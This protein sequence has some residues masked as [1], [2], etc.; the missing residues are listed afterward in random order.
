M[1]EHWYDSLVRHLSRTLKKIQGALLLKVIY[2][3]QSGQIHPMIEKCLASASKAAV[4][5]ILATCEKD[6]ES[7]SKHLFP[8]KKETAT[9]S[10][11]QQLKVLLSNASEGLT[12]QAKKIKDLE[13]ILA[14]QVIEKRRQHESLSEREKEVA[15]LASCLAVKEDRARRLEEVLASRKNENETLVQSVSDK[16]KQLA[17]MEVERSRLCDCLAAKEDEAA[18]VVATCRDAERKLEKASLDFI[19]KEEESRRLRLE[20]TQISDQQRRD[21]QRIAQLETEKGRLSRQVNGLENAC[22]ENDLVIQKLK[23]YDDLLQIPVADVEMTDVEVGRGSYGEVKIGRWRGCH[24]AVK[25]FYDHL[26]GDYYC[27]LFKQEMDVCSRVRHPNVLAVY[28]VTIRQ[29]DTPFRIITKLLEGS[30]LRVIKTGLPLTIRE[31]IDLAFGFTSGIDYLHGLLPN[32]ILHGDI[33]STNILISAMMEAQIA[34]LGTARFVN[35]SL[36]AGVHSRDYLAPERFPPMNCEKTKKS[37]IYS[38]GVTLTELMTGE[39]PLVEKRFSQVLNVRHPDVKDLCQQMI[40]ETPEERPSASDCL[41]HLELVR[42][43][44]SYKD[45]SPKRLVKGVRAVKG[46]PGSE[47]KVVLIRVDWGNEQ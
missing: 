13:D 19:A 34:D 17:L 28:G 26:V 10:S 23:Q 8:M 16:E 14:A 30:L 12:L 33:R 37:D 15:N 9:K 2:N 47:H 27:K 45:C 29:D 20:I 46:Q 40:A 25:T 35:A 4:E 21:G 44:K 39:H 1:A 43:Y 42:D 32:A 36:S 11:F 24:V 18:R 22:K 6:M 3:M 5:E 41:Q 31:R 38:L 7:L